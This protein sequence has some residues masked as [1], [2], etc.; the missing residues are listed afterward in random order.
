MIANSW[1]PSKRVTCA[2]IAISD[3]ST[4]CTNSSEDTYYLVAFP[5]DCQKYVKCSQSGV[6]N[7]V[8][9]VPENLVYNPANGQATSPSQLACAVL[10][11]K[12]SFIMTIFFNV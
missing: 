6:F 9:S 1:Q 3:K 2:R 5:Y 12:S 7:T 11:G 4:I 8:M 10:N